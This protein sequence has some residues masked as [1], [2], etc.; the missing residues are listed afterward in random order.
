MYKQEF[1]DVLAQG[2]PVVRVI[3]VSESLDDN[4][5][6][7][8]YDH[9][10]PKIEATSFRA[11]AHCPCRHSANLRGE[12]CDHTVENCLHLDRIGMKISVSSRTR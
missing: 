10:V 8:P 2:P 5:E 3:P 6:V 9:L 7:L 4:S 11:V 12:G 1:S